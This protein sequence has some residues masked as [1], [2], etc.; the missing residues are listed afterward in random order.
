MVVLEESQKVYKIV[1][2]RIMQLRIRWFKGN[3]IKSL[4]Q[5]IYLMDINKGKCM[6]RKIKRDE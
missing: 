3:L 6:I 4:N 1:L 2:E 5:K